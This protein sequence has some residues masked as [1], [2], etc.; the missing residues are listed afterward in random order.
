MPDRRAFL[1]AAALVATTPLPGGND[2]A[3]DDDPATAECDI[4][5]AA[6]PAGMVDRTT[7]DPIA[8]LEADICAVCQ[9]V[10]N[11][12]LA[13]GVCD[14]C[15]DPAEPGFSIE[16]EYPLGEANLPAFSAWELCGD[17][18]SW[19]ASDIAYRGV[20]AD[21]EAKETYVDLIDA[22]HERGADQEG[23]E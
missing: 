6:K 22:Q 10:Q 8:P 21:P 12:A 11:H 23:S 18:V 4:C 2:T 15:G 17:C 20:D 1:E 16:L 3:A 19:I 7:V 13:D 14:E 5:G 9:F